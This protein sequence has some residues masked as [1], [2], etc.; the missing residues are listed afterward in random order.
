MTEVWKEIPGYAGFEASTESRIRSPKGEIVSQ[1]LSG[2][3][4]YYYVNIFTGDGI[5]AQRRVHVLVALAFIP[6]PENLPIV[7]H[8][9]RDKLNNRISNLRWATRSNNMRNKENAV[10][11]EEGVHILD[12]VQRYEKPKAAYSYIYSRY[13]SGMTVED[14]IAEYSLYLEIGQKR[15]VVDWKGNEVNLFTL[16]ESKGKDYFTTGNRIS[17]GWPVWNAL[18]GVP[19]SYVYSVEIAS[20]LTTGVW[21]PSRKYLC[22]YFGWSSD[23]FLDKLRSGD[24]FEELKTYDPLDSMRRTVLG[25]TGTV[26]EICK[27]FGLTETCVSTRMLRKGM[28]FEEALLVPSERVKVITINGESKSPKVWYEAFGLNARS[29]NSCKARNKFTFKETLDYYEV[30]TSEMVFS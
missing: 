29:A 17:S 12:F 27:H 1:F 10:W 23:G 5:R 28:T 15:R 18:Y 20:S 11:V 2:L 16:C 3:P 14:S 19:P 9:D 8:I 25:V 21:F 22:D 26:G 30:D 13:N 7:D 4:Q 6:N 24:S